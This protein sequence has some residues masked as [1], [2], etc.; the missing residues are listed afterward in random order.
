MTRTSH[1]DLLVAAD[2]PERARLE[3][4]QELDLQVGGH[5][6]DLVEEQRAAVGELEVPGT[7]LV[8][9]G[10][11]AF[12][13]PEKLALDQVRRDRAAVDRHERL[14]APAR[15][16]M[17]RLGGR[18]LAAAALA[19]DHDRRI[20]ARD[21]RDDRARLAHGV[22]DAHHRPEMAGLV[23]GLPQ[24]GVAVLGGASGPEALEHG[25]ELHGTK[26]LDEV[27][28]G[29]RL[30]RLDGRVERSVAR[31]DDDLPARIRQRGRRG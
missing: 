17:D 13:V 4:P 15:Q 23:Q 26:R 1:A 5:L 25:F 27:I 29:A 10:E 6:G 24:G 18:L 28:E 22:R 3:N 31:Q 7:A 14:L 16:G 21:S 12:L 20:R 19:R 9:S 11:G 30:H 2:P 8:G